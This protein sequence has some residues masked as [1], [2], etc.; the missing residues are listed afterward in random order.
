M[1]LTIATGPHTMTPDIDLEVGQVP[2]VTSSDRAFFS[3]S[4]HFPFG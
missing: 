3:L 2:Q 1:Y 4:H